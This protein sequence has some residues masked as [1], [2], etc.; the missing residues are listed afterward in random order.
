MT[1]RLLSTNLQ[2]W[3]ASYDYSAVLMPIVFAT[4]VDAVRRAAPAGGLATTATARMLA[5]YQNH[6]YQ[7]LVDHD[8]LLLLKRP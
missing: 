7:R 6:G 8:G 1:W 5:A 4:L 2:H 3:G